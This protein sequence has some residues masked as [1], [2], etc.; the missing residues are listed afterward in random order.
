MARKILHLDLDAFF[1]AVEEQRDPTLRGRRLRQNG[2]SGVTVRLK[3][4]WADF[5]TLTRQ[6]TLDRPTNLDR[7]IYTAAEQLFGQTWPSGK[8]VR[9]IGVG[10]S[11][12]E[13]D[14][15]QLGLWDSDS[16]PDR[17][18]QATL[19]EL[20]DRF[21]PQAIQRGSHLPPDKEG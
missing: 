16:E 17:R 5:T 7:D 15:Y 9:L 4:R 18:L 10:V 19:D 11:G 14:A 2:L 3:L 1:C 20:R 8:R 6:I 13:T 21:G 12:F